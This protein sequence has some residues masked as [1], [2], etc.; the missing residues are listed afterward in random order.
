MDEKNTIVKIVIA[1]S[2][3]FD[4]YLMLRQKMSWVEDQLT[5][6][7]PFVEI[8]V[9]DGGA[10][11]ADHY[12]RKWAE[13][14]GYK[15]HEYP[16]DW[17]Q[18]GKSAGYIRN[19]EMANDCDMVVVFWDGESKGTKHMMELA[20]KYEKPLVVFNYGKEQKT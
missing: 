20:K 17:K 12:G 14:C 4:N 2:R 10:M 19:E 13:K 7:E 11:G 1:G 8:E 18:F 15:V 9:F 3:T 5:A 6:R 16:A